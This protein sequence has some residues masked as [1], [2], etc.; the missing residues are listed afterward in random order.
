M[1]DSSK[2]LFET[3]RFVPLKI[4]SIESVLKPIDLWFIYKTQKW[5]SSQ[6]ID[7]VLRSIDLVLSSIDESRSVIF[8]SQFYRDLILKG[9]D[10][11]VRNEELLEST[12]KVNFCFSIN[13]NKSI[14]EVLKNS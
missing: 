6:C 2:S 13:D 3:Y 4:R 5:I 1:V 14:F 12:I 8:E 9:T 10:L 7:P 11:Y